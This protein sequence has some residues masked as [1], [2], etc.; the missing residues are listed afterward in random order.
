MCG[1]CIG[2]VGLNDL[3]LCNLLG[4]TE[5]N[6][7]V[8]A[9]S[10]W[11]RY[12]YIYLNVLAKMFQCGGK[13]LMSCVWQLPSDTVIPLCSCSIRDGKGCSSCFW[14]LHRPA[15]RCSL[16]GLGKP[17]QSHNFF[18]LRFQLPFPR[19]VLFEAQILG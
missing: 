1:L 5:A 14:E 2:E 18:S 11:R 13:W 3:R 9:K 15:W 10:R 17:V 19:V 16:T 7:K 8:A 12:L 4:K 6:L